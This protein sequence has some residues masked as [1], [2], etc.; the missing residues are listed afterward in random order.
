MPQ[1]LKF[2]LDNLKVSL[3]DPSNP[4]EFNPRLIWEDGKKVFINTAL[5]DL[6]KLLDEKKGCFS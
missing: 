6:Q 2:I 3:E 4:D 5:S 1:H